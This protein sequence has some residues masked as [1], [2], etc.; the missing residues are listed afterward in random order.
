MSTD[1]KT[2]LIVFVKNAV[3]GKAKTRLAKSIGEIA[4]L[5]VYRQLLQLTL[6]A[7]QNLD[8]KKY[9]FYSDTI[10]EADEWQQKGFI[11]KLQKG[12][13]LGERMSN[14]FEEVF[15]NKAQSA[16]IIGSDCP[17]ITKDILLNAFNAL[18]EKDCVIGP[19][20]DGGYYLL[21]LN[22]LE[23][24]IFQNK[25][26]STSTV[27]SDTIKNFETNNW[28]YSVLDSLRDIDTIDDL[29][30][31]KEHLSTDEAFPF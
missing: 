29:K 4:A 8:C 21:G 16:I 19:A 22:Q 17:Q 25:K 13:D 31:F 23:K 9:V 11:Q 6:A 3:M 15:Q 20:E 5:N 30:F 10:E 27:L 7:T 28:A 12:K 26:W 18:I 2:A 24:N 1:K 14:A